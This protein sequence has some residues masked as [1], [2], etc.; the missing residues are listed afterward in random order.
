MAGTRFYASNAGSEYIHFFDLNQGPR[1]IGG[2]T[3]P[4]ARLEPTVPT[5]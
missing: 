4:G 2:T 3:P 5:A 1:V